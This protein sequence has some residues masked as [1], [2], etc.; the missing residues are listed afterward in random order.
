MAAWRRECVC[1][2]GGN[3]SISAPVPSPTVCVHVRTWSGKK[4]ASTVFAYETWTWVVLVCGNVCDPCMCVWCLTFVSECVSVIAAL[5]CVSL[6]LCVGD[7]KVLIST[8]T[9]HQ[10][11]CEGTKQHRPQQNLP[12]K[13]VREVL[14]KC[15]LF[16]PFGFRFSVDSITHLC[17]I[18]QLYGHWHGIKILNNNKII[19][20]LLLKDEN[21][22]L[23]SVE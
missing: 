19:S 11:H 4:M 1:V 12:T 14:E 18:T 6:C 13:T 3:H 23:L 7:I 17:Q 22:L 8:A 20:C 15:F 16:F 9:Q 10:C 5:D 2:G 21:L